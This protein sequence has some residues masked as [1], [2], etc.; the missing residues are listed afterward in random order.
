MIELPG[1]TLADTSASDCGFYLKP[2]F[3]WRARQEY[4]ILKP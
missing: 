4:C 2:S 3:A 1:R